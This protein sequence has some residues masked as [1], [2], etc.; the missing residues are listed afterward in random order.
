MSNTI[1]NQEIRIDKNEMCREKKSSGKHGADGS[2]SHA[3]LHLL[4]GR[5]LCELAGHGLLHA[6]AG[7]DFTSCSAATFLPSRRALPPPHAGMRR[8][9]CPMLVAGGQPC[10]ALVGGGYP[11]CACLRCGQP[12]RTLVGGGHTCCALVAGGHPC[13]ALVAGGHPCSQGGSL[14]AVLARRSSSI[15]HSPALHPVVV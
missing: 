11:C 15:I 3:C 7:G 10:C 4:G 5:W 2:S 8:P 1:G 13:C 9:P 6:L 14:R 12:C